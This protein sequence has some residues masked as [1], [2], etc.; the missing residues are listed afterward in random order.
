MHKRTVYSLLLIS[1]IVVISASLSFANTVTVESK[2]NIP[3]CAEQVADV[4]IAPSQPI[5]AAEVVLVVTEGGNGGFLTV[6]SVVWDAAG[7]ADLPDV[8][9]D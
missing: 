9:V 3:R 8:I 7:T 6:D 1:F 4:T 2:V 5:S